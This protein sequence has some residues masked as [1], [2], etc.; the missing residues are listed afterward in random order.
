M[1]NSKFKMQNSKLQLKIKSFFKKTSNTFNFELLTFNFAT[2]SQRG[3]IILILL[4]VMTVA[5]GI[6]LS[7]V[8]RSLTDISTS[9]KVEQSSRA[10]SAAEAGIEKAIKGDLTAVSFPDA[11]SSAATSVS[12]PEFNQ[13]LEYPPIGKEEIAHFWLADLTSTLNPPP[14]YYTQGS[15]DIYWGT[16]GLPAS[17]QAAI[18]INVVH[19]PAGT[20]QT[21]KFF[22]DPVG[23]RRGENGFSDPG[24]CSSFTIATTSGPSRSFFCRVNLSFAGLG[25]RMVL[26]TRLL[27]TGVSQPIVLQPL[28]GCGKDCSL[29]KQAKIY[30]AIGSS[31]ETQRTVQLF[32]LDKVVP[33]Y[34]DYAIFSAGPIE[35]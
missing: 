9:T 33:F 15:I 26:R 21:K 7:I 6:G 31:G 16:P 28:G 35:K 20:Y 3:Q 25:N 32:T 8:Q 11:Q 30:T 17:D 1:I 24:A 19:Y 4:L 27:Y 10:F 14:A 34:F 2:K 22:Y 18:E 29:P 5:L 23:S 12:L 13:A